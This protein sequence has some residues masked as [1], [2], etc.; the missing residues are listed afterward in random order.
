MDQV[1][2]A[3]PPMAIRFM[4]CRSHDDK[5][6]ARAAEGRVGYRGRMRR[7]GKMVI[8]REICQRLLMMAKFHS[9]RDTVTVDGRLETPDDIIVIGV[10]RT[11]E[12]CG[13]NQPGI[14]NCHIERV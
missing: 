7:K 12:I 2:L 1:V 9:V 3:N 10:V 5:M 6:W 8:L 14:R 13:H 4:F 11:T